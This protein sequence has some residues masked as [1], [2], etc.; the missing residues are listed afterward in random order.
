M[1]KGEDSHEHSP[2]ISLFNNKIN[3]NRESFIFIFMKKRLLEQSIFLSDGVQLTAGWN[4][5]E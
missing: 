5:H 1:K 3:S 2:S 4:V